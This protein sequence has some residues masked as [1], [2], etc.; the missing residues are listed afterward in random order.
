MSKTKTDK[1]AKEPEYLNNAE[2]IVD[3]IMSLPKKE[4]VAWLEE[5]LRRNEDMLARAY[6]DNW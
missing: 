2:E 1:P 6:A 4:A 3:Y 5:A